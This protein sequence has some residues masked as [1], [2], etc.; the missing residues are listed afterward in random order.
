MTDSTAF[1]DTQFRRQIETQEFVLNPFEE[2]ALPYLKG[3]LLDLGCG[4]GNLAL[5]AGRRG[6]EVLALDASSAAVERIHRDAASENLK[7]QAV[8]A[9]LGCYVI[10]GDYDTVVSIGLLMFFPRVKALELLQALQDHVK[11]GGIAIVNVLVDGTT[12]LDMFRKGHYTLFGR[13]ELE[14]RFA[15]WDICLSRIDAFD[16]PGGTCKRF[17]TVIA[18][19]PAS[20]LQ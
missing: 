8:T 2:V 15:G 10:K 19:K 6:C 13:E 7:I 17:S 12:Y 9:D 11:E 20:D 16:A 4:L 5:E 3:R 14:Q 18:R 1:F